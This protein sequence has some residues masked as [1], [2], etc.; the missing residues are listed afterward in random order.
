MIY[1]TFA[2]LY[3]ELMEPSMYDEWLQLVENNFKP[4]AGPVLDLACGAGRLATMMAQKGYHV[5][6]FDLSAEML[7]LADGHAQDAKVELPLIQGDMTDLSA[8]GQFSLITCFADSFCYL[9]EPKLL[10]VT[11]KQVAKHLTDD[12]LFIFDVITPYQTDE[13]YPGYMYNFTD[14]DRAFVWQSFYDEAEHSVIHDLNFFIYNEQTDSYDR[15]NELHHERTYPLAVYQQLLAEAG[16][17][18]VEVT[19]NFGKDEI[20]DETTRWFFR[21][22]K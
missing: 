3:D 20:S 19:A 8:L 1:Q 22:Q 13:V 2:K 21:C 9:P 17:S 11:F 7:A 16:F 15:I 14:D 5:T 10:A 4:T 6:G 12:G 18:K